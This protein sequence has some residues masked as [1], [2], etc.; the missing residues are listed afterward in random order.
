MN[1]LAMTHMQISATMSTKKIV[2]R[3]EYRKDCRQCQTDVFKNI[4]EE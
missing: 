1:Q 4:S 2:Y 3:S